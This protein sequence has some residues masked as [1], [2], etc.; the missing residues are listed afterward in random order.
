[1][2]LETMEAFLPFLHGQWRPAGQCPA[3]P[4]C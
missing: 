1:M 2:D 4:R 3:W